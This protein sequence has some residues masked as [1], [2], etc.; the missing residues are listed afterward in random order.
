LVFINTI[1]VLASPRTFTSVL[2]SVVLNALFEKA[3]LFTEREICLKESTTFDA[4]PASKATATSDERYILSV[5]DESK[6]TFALSF[7]AAV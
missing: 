6:M 7:C 3:F 1:R 5:V 4:K 2:I